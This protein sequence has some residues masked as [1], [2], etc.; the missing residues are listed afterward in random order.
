MPDRPSWTEAQLRDLALNYRNAY[1]KNES[2]LDAALA[3]L[4]F[5]ENQ[6]PED[7]DQGAIFAAMFGEALRCW[8]EELTEVVSEP[9]EK[10]CENPS[11]STD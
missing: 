4:R 10:D 11:R 5:V 1:A 6:F 8:G 2:R 3:A 7:E 9:H